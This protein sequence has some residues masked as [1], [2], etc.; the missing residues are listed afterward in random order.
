VIVSDNLGMG[1]Y[2]F[3]NLIAIMT[4]SRTKSSPNQ[5]TAA[6][7]PL[8]ALKL[9]LKELQSYRTTGA[10][11]GKGKQVDNSAL[12]NLDEDDGV[13]LDFAGLKFVIL[14]VRM[15]SGTMMMIWEMRRGSSTSYPVSLCILPH[16][17][18][19]LTV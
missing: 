8:K 2:L 14:M 10:G 19:E 4:R 13:S 5:Y 7:F 12:D 16:S 3:A 15:R 18:F 11:K 6:P 1:D 9:I 17:D